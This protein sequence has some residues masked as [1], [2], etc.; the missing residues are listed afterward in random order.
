A[1]STIFRASSN[2]GVTFWYTVIRNEVFPFASA[3]LIAEI[4][5]A[6]SLAL[7]RDTVSG[8][9]HATG[10]KNGKARQGER[11]NWEMKSV[12]VIRSGGVG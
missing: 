8:K 3:A 1:S 5:Q 4:K 6:R 2:F 9:E 12:T 10:L 11:Q 7:A